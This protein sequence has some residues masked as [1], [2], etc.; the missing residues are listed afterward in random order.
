MARN[1]MGMSTIDSQPGQIAEGQHGRG[2]AGEVQRILQVEVLGFLLTGHNPG[3]RGLSALPRA[4][5]RDN[6][7]E[8]QCLP[9]G[10]QVMQPVDDRALLYLRIGTLSI[11]FQG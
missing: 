2:Q 8:F 3:E 11:D 6:G 1:A 4:E 5:Q 9:Q 7:V 10:G